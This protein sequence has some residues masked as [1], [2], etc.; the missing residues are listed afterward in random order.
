MLKTT[1]CDI[2]T[3]DCTVE[4]KVLDPQRHVFHRV[5]IGSTGPPAGA[6]GRRLQRKMQQL[7]K[8]Q[9]T[10]ESYGSVTK[11]LGH[12]TVALLKMDIEGYEYQVGCGVR[13]AAA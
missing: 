7:G 11:R 13:A 9:G 2:H 6:A 8:V 1:K 4:G 12:H 3:F 5:C 10:F